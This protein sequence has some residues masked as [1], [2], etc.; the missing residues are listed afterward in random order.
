MRSAYRILVRKPEGKR[1]LGKLKH[2]VKVTI[3]MDLKE[4]GYKNVDWI[5]TYLLRGAGYC[6]KS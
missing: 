6:L 3:K 2:K 1:S 5:L 4:T